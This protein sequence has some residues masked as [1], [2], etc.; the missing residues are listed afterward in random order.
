MMGPTIG[1]ARLLEY[2]CWSRKKI[3]EGEG[4]DCRRMSFFTGFSFILKT[5]TNGFKGKVQPQG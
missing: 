5:K 4:L 3:K 2:R 1:A